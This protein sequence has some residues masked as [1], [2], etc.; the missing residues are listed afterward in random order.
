MDNI[1]H[2][3]LGLYE[4]LIKGGKI[5]KDNNDCDYFDDGCNV[6]NECFSQQ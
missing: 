4:N 2:S 5:D 3:V 1:N 6:G